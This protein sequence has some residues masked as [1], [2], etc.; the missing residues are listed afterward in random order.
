MGNIIFIPASAEPGYSGPSGGYTYEYVSKNLN[1]HDYVL[2]Y[3]SNRVSTIIYDLGG[4][5]S[6]T[7]TLSYTGNKLTTVT[8]SGDTPL[9]IALTKTL[10]YTG[11][12]LTGVTYS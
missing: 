10:A 9:G 5:L 2:S 8:L 1:S 11:A 7:K 3:I 12:N 6:I 4:G